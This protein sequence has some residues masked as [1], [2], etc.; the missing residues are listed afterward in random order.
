MKAKAGPALN[1][2]KLKKVEEIR[3]AINTHLEA[4][5]K[6]YKSGKGQDIDTANKNMFALLDSLKFSPNDEFYVQMRNHSWQRNHLKILGSISDLMQRNNCMPTNT[7]ISIEAG[8]SEETVYKHL[9][10]FKKHPLYEH[11]ADKFQF[12]KNRVLTTV[13]NLGVQGDV[14]ACKVYLDYFKTSN[15]GPPHNYQQ[16][17]FIQF[18]S[19]KLTL[20]DIVNLPIDVKNRIEQLILKPTPEKEIEIV[21]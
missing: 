11:D 8:L 15:E 13:F 21:L 16:N 7:A 5:N 9:R 17:N 19:L 6:A 10:D 18:N 1:P 12:M 2:K 3:I 14:R 4:I 20:E